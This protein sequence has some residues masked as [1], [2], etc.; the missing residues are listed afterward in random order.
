MKRHIAT[1]I[2]FLSLGLKISA[3][4]IMTIDDIKEFQQIGF[5]KSIIE[6]LT[7]P[8]FE[9]RDVLSAN[10]YRTQRYIENIL[11]TYN[12]K[13]YFDNYKV[14]YKI[15]SVTYGQ[16]IVAVYRGSERK[17]GAILITANYDNLG[18]NNSFSNEYEAYPGANDNASGVSALIQIALFIEK[19]KPK[20]NIIFAF[21]SGKKMGMIGAGFLADTLVKKNDLV[22]NY[23]INIEQIGRP[24]DNSCNN[25]ISIQD[26][27]NNVVN[28]F[29]E[30][31]GEDF[32]ARD[33]SPENTFRSEHTPIFNVLK[34]PTTTLT[35]FN[36]ANDENYMTPLDNVEN[37]NINYIHRTTARI[38]FAIW[39]IITEER[40]VNFKENSIGLSKI[41]TKVNY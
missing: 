19:N 3:Q 28:L 1:L 31:V 39:K 24:M 15:D 37:V 14:N 23:A 25:L 17:K 33:N 5:T 40:K 27:T 8:Y 26:T 11:K 20:E 36:F 13:T 10:I 34:V 38:S 6:N 16:N 4:Q 7:S 35:S 21:T 9:G 12:I 18:I 30:F 41:Q 29:N 22:V 2:L 32:I